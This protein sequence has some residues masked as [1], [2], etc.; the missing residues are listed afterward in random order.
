MVGKRI[1]NKIHQEGRKKN[2]KEL[3]CKMWFDSWNI[4]E[5]SCP[6]DR[7]EL[8]IHLQKCYRKETLRGSNN[9]HGQYQPRL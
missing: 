1:S 4:V 7:K 8:K 2:T 6:M 5:V 9:L 3:Q